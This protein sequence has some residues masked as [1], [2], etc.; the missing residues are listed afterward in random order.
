MRE[1]RMAY[2]VSERQRF[3]KFLVQ[4]EHGC[5]G[6]GD[7]RHFERMGEP[8]PEMIAQAGREN[9][10]FAFQP[11]KTPR[12]DDTVTVALVIV[13]VRVRKL[14]IFAAAGRFRR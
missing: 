6:P 14:G 5:R 12:V 3:C 8:V 13:S 11:A 2:V 9:L 1:R 7:L 10:C 4:S